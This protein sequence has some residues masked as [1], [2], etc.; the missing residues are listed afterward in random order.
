M[1]GTGPSAGAWTVPTAEFTRSLA[2]RVPAERLPAV[3][4]FA[5]AYTRRLGPAELADL[6]PVELA[7]QVAGQS[8]GLRVVEEVPTDLIHDVADERFLQDF[9]VLAA[10]GRPL[11]VEAL[12][13][14]VAECIA[15]VWRGD[16]EMDSLNRL[17]LSAGMDWRQVQILR[18][19]RKYPA[20]TVAVRQIRALGLEA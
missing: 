8:L 12:G 6:R 20:A 5:Y 7:G 10:D 9:G 1:G 3:E 4:A 19:Y 13:P 14:R 2:E 16:C 18:A 17:V 15:A 11:D